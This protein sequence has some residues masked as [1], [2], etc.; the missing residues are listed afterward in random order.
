LRKKFHFPA[1][2]KFIYKFIQCD[3]KMLSGG[4]QDKIQPFFRNRTRSPSA[5]SSTTL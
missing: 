2:Q 3:M 1:P 4:L 5:V